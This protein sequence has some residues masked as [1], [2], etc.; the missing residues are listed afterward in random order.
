MTLLAIDNLSIALPKG[1]DRDL[2]VKDV[3][4]TLDKGEI[5]CIVGESGSG[6][7]MAANALMGLLP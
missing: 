3:S 4:L 6:K 2:A 5:L 1:A 7:S